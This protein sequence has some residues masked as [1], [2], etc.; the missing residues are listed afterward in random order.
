[1]IASAF[2]ELPDEPQFAEDRINCDLK[3]GQVARNAGDVEAAIKHTADA[4]ARFATLRFPSMVRDME[5]F[6]AAGEDY[7]VAG[8]YREASEAFEQAYARLVALGREHTDTASTLFNNWGLSLHLAGRTLEAEPLFKRAIQNSMADGHE[9]AVSPMLL[10]NYARV[11]DRLNRDAEAATYAERADRRARASSDEVI[12]NQALLMRAGIYVKLRDVRR[13]QAMLDEAEPR[14][15][16][17]LPAGHLAFASLAAYRALVAQAEGRIG[18]AREAANRAVAIGEV[19]GGESAGLPFWL[20]RRA[21]IELAAGQWPA[22][23][24][25][26]RRTLALEQEA[27]A[28]DAPSSNIGVAYLALGRALQGE[29]D[30][31]AAARGVCVRADPAAADVG[32]IA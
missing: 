6:G 7:R 22:A 31:A 26:A 8:R 15:L 18:D 16:R 14:L 3:A 21:D 19:E 25:D 12:I 29:G 30:I 5:I 17:M 11:L 27:V 20:Q 32:C 13:A 24:A 28:S 9:A 4:R 1:M 2:A 23:L 10:L